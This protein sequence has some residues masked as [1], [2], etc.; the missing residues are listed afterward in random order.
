MI[1]VEVALYSEVSSEAENNLVAWLLSVLSSWVGWGVTQGGRAG[2]GCGR[3]QGS[4]SPAHA[5]QPCPGGGR[6]AESR[7]LPVRFCPICPCPD[8]QMPSVFAQACSAVSPSSARDT[9]IA[10]LFGTCVATGQVVLPLEMP[11]KEA[12]PRRSPI[13]TANEWKQAGGPL[14]RGPLPHAPPGSGADQLRGDGHALQS[15]RKSRAAQRFSG[16]PPPHSQID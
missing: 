12:W 9:A 4:P 2:G 6:A 11:V 5:A 3:T 8:A 7:R 13:S 10:S 16:C 14:G 1:R 15:Q